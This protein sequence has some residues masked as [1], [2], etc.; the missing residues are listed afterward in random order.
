MSCG[1]VMVISAQLPVGTSRKIRQHLRQV[2][3]SLEVVYSP[4]NLRLGEAIGCY[5]KP[6]HVVI[7]AEAPEAGDA[8]EGL[9][10]PMQAQCIRMNL[11][12]AELVKHCL[13]SFLAASVTL[14]NQW[15]DIAAA[16]G[17]DF[18]DVAVALRADPRIG[19]RAYITPGIGF[20]GGT[21]GRDLRV[22]DAVNRS[23]LGGRAPIF[24]QIWDY[25]QRRV[26]VVARRA[27]E[28]LGGLS[29]RRIGLLGMTY[30]PG[31]STMRRSLPL[32]VARDLLA[33]GTAVRAHDPKADWAEVA[34][35]EGLEVAETPYQAA[36]GA[37]MVIL[38]TEWPDYRDLDFRRL[39]GAMRKPFL[40]DT[41]GF[42]KGKER[43]LR[44]SG[45]TTVTLAPAAGA[46]EG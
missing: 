22:L 28:V 11:P 16:M 21:L 36:V 23:A 14:A 19:G 40:L 33:H 20:S 6:G 30:K 18:A 32:A 37:D 43:E 44:A 25:N 39:A 26:E 24:G 31:T 38:L 13:N 41:K 10:A 5:L 29:E 35:P 2:D 34:L 42:L 1:T 3:E 12:S 17:A 8:V 9:F 45:L 46:P 7:G 4:E 15:A 27:S